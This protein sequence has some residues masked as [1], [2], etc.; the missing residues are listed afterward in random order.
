MYLLKSPPP[1]YNGMDSVGDNRVFTRDLVL[2][3]CSIQLKESIQSRG[4][5]EAL[6]VWRNCEGPPLSCPSELPSSEA[7][8]GYFGLHL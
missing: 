7:N 1:N 4:E 8:R 3:I 2:H 5:T 6:L